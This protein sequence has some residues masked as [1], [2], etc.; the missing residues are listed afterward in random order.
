LG[1]PVLQGALFAT[2]AVTLSIFFVI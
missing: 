1:T 2:V